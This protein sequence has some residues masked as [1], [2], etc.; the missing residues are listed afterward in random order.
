MVEIHEQLIVLSLTYGMAFYAVAIVI[1]LEWRRDS[2][3]PFTRALPSLAV[4]GFLL[5]LVETIDVLM[6]VHIDLGASIA[7]LATLRA[8]LVGSA[9]LFLLWFGVSLVTRGTSR[10][11]WMRLIA[12]A[13]FL[14]WAVGSLE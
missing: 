3:L 7:W 2:P 9:Y 6:F 5:G 11:R 4:F 14:L 1:V 13:L 10:R 12:P 8:A